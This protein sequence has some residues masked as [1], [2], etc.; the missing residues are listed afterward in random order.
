MQEWCCYVLPRPTGCNTSMRSC[1]RFQTVNAQREKLVGL[2]KQP[3]KLSHFVSVSTICVYHYVLVSQLERSP[4]NFYWDKRTTNNPLFCGHS[5]CELYR[6]CN[7][8][9]FLKIIQIVKTVFDLLLA[10]GGRHTNHSGSATTTF[11][12]R[13]S[14]SCVLGVPISNMGNHP[15][16][17]IFRLHGRI[18][19]ADGHQDV[20]IDL[21]I[22]HDCWSYYEAD[23]YRYLRSF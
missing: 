3:C 12:S 5:N 23:A 18:W 1:S 10:H 8:P 2:S 17:H 11:H 19:N 16:W 7:T 20:I 14:S 6:H 13:L 9:Q 21:S 15:H 4:A 22:Y